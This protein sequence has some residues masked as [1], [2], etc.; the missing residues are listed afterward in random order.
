MSITI[1]IA[2][3]IKGT[4][5]Q[6]LILTKIRVPDNLPIKNTTPPQAARMQNTL[7]HQSGDK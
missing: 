7:T 3:A 1:T 5:N 2:V 4:K 6:K